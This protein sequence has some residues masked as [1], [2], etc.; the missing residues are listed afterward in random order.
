MSYLS[1]SRYEEA[2]DGDRLIGVPRTDLDRF[3][4]YVTYT[5]VYGERLDQ[6]AG[7]VFGDPTRWWE[8]ADLNP[9]VSFP[10]DI[11]AGTTLRVPA[12]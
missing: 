1:T 4:K 7:R 8:I 10:G 12:S 3:V 5:T 6:I 2:Q 11:P 9:E